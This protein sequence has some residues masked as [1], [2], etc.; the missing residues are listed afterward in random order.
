MSR[1]FLLGGFV[2]FTVVFFVSF[3]SGANIHASLLNGMIGCIIL[4]IL[5]RFLCSRIINAIVLA[6]LKELKQLEN[7][8][9]KENS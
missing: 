3:S 2:G 4:A 9:P 1:Y 5:V 8:P 7:E 6:K